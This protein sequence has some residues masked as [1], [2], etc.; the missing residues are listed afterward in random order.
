MGQLSQLLVHKLTSAVGIPLPSDASG[1]GDFLT[2]LLFTDKL[3][4]Y[5]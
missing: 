1:G 5:I 4:S 3:L 2:V